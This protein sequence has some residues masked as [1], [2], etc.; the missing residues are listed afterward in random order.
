MATQPRIIYSQ[1]NRFRDAPAVACYSWPLNEVSDVS[2]T[3]SGIGEVINFETKMPNWRH[4]IA[5]GLN[6]TTVFDAEEISLTYS[7]GSLF[8]GKWCAGSVN[9][10]VYYSYY[11]DLAIGHPNV[12]TRPAAAP[13]S[14]DNQTHDEAL[15]RF[16]R[17]ARSKQNHFRGGNFI[18]ELGDT[19]RGFRNPVKGFRDLLDTYHRNARRRVKR[20][21][22][23]RPIPVSQQD[24]R[25]LERDAPDVGRAAQR[26]LSD[27]WLE[28]NFG[29]SPLLSDAVDA[30]HGL[31][32]LAARVPLSRCYGTSDRDDPPTYT[33]T[34][35]NH[36]GPTITWVTRTQTKYDVTFYGAVKVEVN[37]PT[38]AAVEEMGVR[39][40]DFLPAVWEAIPYSFLIDYFANVGDIIEAVSF[41]RS[42]LAW[43]SR[44]F[45][46]TVNRSTEQCTIEEISSPPYPASLS[47]KVFDF[48]PSRVEWNRKY[49]NR[50][51]Y[52][53]SLV[54]SLRFEIPGSKN[55][56]KWC[57]VAALARLRTL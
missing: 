1:R 9:R 26:A 52:S 27:S 31:R 34:D 25:R 3:T 21:V 32:A 24:F 18:A 45:R 13:S 29:W 39:A 33:S 11:G 6:A 36:S 44:T 55:W 28:A 8:H 37:S 22:G 4:R 50:T 42:D 49:I 2:L 48:Q 16:L 46:N 15:S 17:D 30:Y 20:A 54:P 23:R 56:R 14:V 51:P 35:R 53:D 7:P 19:I 10:F 41:P 57:N 40:R 38:G 47:W 43:V 12:W 5:R